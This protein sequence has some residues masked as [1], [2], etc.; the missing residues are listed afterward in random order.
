MPPADP[1]DLDGIIEMLVKGTEAGLDGLG[2]TDDLPWY[3]YQFFFDR[4]FTFDKWREPTP[5]VFYDEVQKL[6]LKRGPDAVALVTM[7]W[8]SVPS[9]PG[10]PSSDPRR[11]EAF[12]F[13]V[14]DSKL[15]IRAASMKIRRRKDKHPVVKNILFTD[16]VAGAMPDRIRTAMTMAHLHSAN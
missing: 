10:R 8:T 12:N 5:E 2:P 13:L 1:H 11:G 4:K 6:I 15:E 7:A 3:L 16:E 9:H 14:C